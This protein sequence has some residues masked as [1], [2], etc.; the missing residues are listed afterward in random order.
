MSGVTSLAVV[1]PSYGVKRHI[2]DVIASIG[3]ECEAI[4]VVDDVC[5]EETGAWVAA[6]CRD[7]RVRVLRHETNQGVG[8]ATITGLRAALADGARVI[9]KLDGDGQMDPTFIPRLVRPILEGE[10]DYT[11]GNRF[12]DPDGLRAMP[13]LRLFGNSILSF[14]SKLSSGYWNIFDPTNGFTA[15]HRETAL[16]MPLE[17]LSR[18]W[19]FESD[20]LFRL[21]TLRAVVVDVPMPARY[22]N[23]RSS[24]VIRRIVGEFAF[25][26]LRNFFKRIFYN[27]Y[28][29]NFNIASIEIVLGI[30]F[31]L[32]GSW[33]G[34]TR[35]I[36]S[37]REGLPATAGTVMLA[38]LPILIGVQLILAFLSYDLQNVPREVIHRRLEAPPAIADPGAA[39]GASSFG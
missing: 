35:W 1:I 30:L 15:I 10:A 27:Y 8:G 12:F 13:S 38:A 17:K 21:G 18:R 11:K 29:R 33:V 31:L 39:R 3:P 7:P 28:L 22:Q 25:K 14:A 6:Q 2:L 32:L 4:Y 19:F 36:E 24:L 34:V 26:H 5:P 23:E 37:A 20:M 16:A 9:V